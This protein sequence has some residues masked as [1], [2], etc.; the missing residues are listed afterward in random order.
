MDERLEPWYR[1]T[2]RWGQTN[3]TEVDPARYDADWWRDY[4]RRTRVQGVIINAGG[5]VGYYPSR[6]PLQHR[7]EHLGERDL[8]GEIVSAAR[9][10]GLT[11]LARMDSNRAHEPFYLEHPDWFAIDP[12]GVPYRAGE[13]F[14][15]CVNS[16][17]YDEYLPAVLAEI[18]ERSRPDGFADNSWSGLPNTKICYCDN[19]ER[20]FTDATRLRLPTRRDWTDTAFQRWIRWNYA[21]RIEIWELNNRTTKA[22]GGEHCLWLGMNGGSIEGQ[23]QAFRD[24]KAIGE[25]SPIVMLD[26]QGRRDGGSFSANSEAGKLIH[27]LIG[28]DKLIPESTAMYGNGT[29]TFRLG[30]KPAPEARMWVLEGFASGI[31]P[32]WHHIGAFHEDRRQYATAESFFTWHERHQEFLINRTPVATV[33]VLWCQDSVDFYG[34]DEVTTKITLPRQGM[35]NALIRARIPFRPVHVDHLARD[36]DGLSTVIV[37]NLGALSDDQCAAIREFV[38]AGGG[39]VITG[40]SSRYDEWGDPRPDFALADVIG[41]HATGSH[42][43]S[44]DDATTNWESWAKHTYLRLPPEARDTAAGPRSPEPVVPVERP[45]ALAGFEGTDL[46]PFAGRI[47]VITPEDPGQ[48]PVTLVP[49]F[50]I[51]PPE[52]SWIRRPASSVPALILREYGSGRVAYLAADL[53]RCFG[54]DGQPDHGRLLANLVRWTH[55]EPLPIM[56]TG[57]G[58]LDCQLYRQDDRLILHLVNLTATQTGRAP[59]HEFIPVGPFQIDVQVPQGATQ[60]R[61]LVT[62]EA[63]DVET[64]GGRARLTVERIVDHEVIVISLD[65]VEDSAV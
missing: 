47:E 28:W 59:I 41:A 42:H 8:Y 51:Y 36:A 60:A 38:A 15:S 4:W 34:R 48:V 52:T 22:A 11:V 20:R 25:R 29:P 37:P 65:T 50:P 21:R 63:L 23:S 57:T 43:G 53:D 44:A 61:S 2:L 54:R 19:C 58:T 27:G 39:L 12:E 45:E 31:Q 26:H 24:H 17:Y 9:E 33:G 30:S 13:L 6:F 1:R 56:I 5:I 3:L 7:A 46:L 18:I 64:A 55:R 40:E 35:V 14:V 16:P 62:E 10:D 49:P 32:W